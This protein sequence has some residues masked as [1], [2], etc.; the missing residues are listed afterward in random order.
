MSS[1]LFTQLKYIIFYIFICNVDCGCFLLE[2]LKS[3]LITVISILCINHS[4]SHGKLLPQWL[5]VASSQSCTYLLLY[6]RVWEPYER[7]GTVL[8]YNWSE[9]IE[10]SLCVICLQFYVLSENQWKHK[11]RL[12]K[13]SVNATQSFYPRLQNYFTCFRWITVKE[14]LLWMGYRPWSIRCPTFL[15]LSSQRE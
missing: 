7:T 12:F 6:N 5:P 13:E 2:T 3:I 1:Y 15:L 14:L 11:F 9:Y 8:P 10:R 4:P